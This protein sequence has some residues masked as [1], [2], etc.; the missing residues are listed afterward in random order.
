MRQ[1]LNL[2]IKSDAASTDELVELTREVNQ[3][4]NQNIA[5][6]EI[7]SPEGKIQPGDK[8][9]KEIFGAL[10]VFFEKLDVLDKIVQCLTVYIK[11][12]RRTV[13]ITVSN[14]A[15]KSISLSAE[16]IGKAELSDLILQI[17]DL[18]AT[19]SG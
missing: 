15:G 13:S 10:N 6:C 7:R 17:R 4:I 16:N 3:W 19:D 14:Q 12:R 1:T 9:V 18:A 5:D 2:E 11:E 8:G